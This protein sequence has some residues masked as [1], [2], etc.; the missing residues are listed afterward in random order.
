MWFQV[1]LRRGHMRECLRIRCQGV[2]IN[3]PRCTLLSHISLLVLLIC[4]KHHAACELPCLSC[5][6]FFFSFMC[7]RVC[8]AASSVSFLLHRLGSD[9][10]KLSQNPPLPPFYSKCVQL[11]QEHCAFSFTVNSGTVLAKA[12]AR[13]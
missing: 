12:A 2:C 3:I 10:A 5:V 9:E 6:P 13:P 7:L 11:V 1:C 8:S 4:F